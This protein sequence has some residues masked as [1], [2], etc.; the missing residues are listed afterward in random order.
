MHFRFIRINRWH[1]RWHQHVRT[2]V[3]LKHTSDLQKTTSRL[4][5]ETTPQYSGAQNTE[6]PPNSVNISEPLKKITLTTLFH[7]ASLHQD[8]PTT[9]HAKDATSASKK[10]YLSSANLNYHHARNVIISG[11]HRN[12]ALLCNNWTKH[13]NLPPRLLR[14]FVLYIN[15]GYEYSL[16]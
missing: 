6:T 15:Y 13:L 5:T 12:K 7:G 10:N 2:T 14:K 16:R 4:D 3:P 11:R 8:H 9:A 1:C